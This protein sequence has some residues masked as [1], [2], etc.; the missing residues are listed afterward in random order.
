MSNR[1]S[2]KTRIKYQKKLYRIIQSE[3][4]VSVKGSKICRTTKKAFCKK[5]VEVSCS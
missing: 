3:M 5:L 4:V 2:G 1:D